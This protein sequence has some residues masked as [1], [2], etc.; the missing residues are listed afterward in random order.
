MAQEVDISYAK[1]VKG[2]IHTWFDS[3]RHA[4]KTIDYDPNYPLSVTFDFG[5]ADPTSVILIQEKKNIVYILKHFEVK[6]TI[7]PKIMDQ[8]AQV[9]RQ[10]KL[11]IKDINGWYGD[12]DARNRDRIHG[13]SIANWIWDRYRV[14]FKFK[15][16][17]VPRHRITSVRL[18]GESNRIIIDKDQSLFIDTTENYKFPEKE[19]GENEKPLH[20]WCSHAQSAL[21]YYCV[22]EHGMNEYEQAQTIQSI[23]IR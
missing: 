5:I 15:Y 1:S 9:I 18:L 13:D 8:L 20:D 22:V 4:N 17:N 12:P 10:W 11:D 14:R 6:D 23:R 2:K 21:E 16:P 7:F 19:H 3:E